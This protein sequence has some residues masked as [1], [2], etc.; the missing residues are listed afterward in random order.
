MLTLCVSDVQTLGARFTSDGRWQGQESV[1]TIQCDQANNACQVRVPAPGAALV[2]FSDDAF[3]HSGLGP[4]G[5][6]QLEVFTTT[7]YTKLH[8]TAT[9]DQAVLETSN[10]HG[11]EAMN[12]FGSTSQGATKQSGAAAA[13]GAASALLGVVLGAAG[14]LLLAARR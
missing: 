12:V 2:F 6:Q 4:Q 7:Y 13:R 11:G 9:V 3:A 10:G 14:L 5:A 1:Q 8:N